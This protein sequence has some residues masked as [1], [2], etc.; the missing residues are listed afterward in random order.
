MSITDIERI[1]DRVTGF[2]VDLGLPPESWA[3]STYA[4]RY[5][6]VVV[7]VSVFEAAGACWVRV[8]APV[9]EEFRPNLE[10]VTRILRLNTELLLG[11]FVIFEDDTLS[12]SVTLAG[13]GLEREPF[14]I[15][16]DHVARIANAYGDEL[17]TIAGGRSILDVLEP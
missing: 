16:L 10:L 8:A 11:S 7:F 2:L 12:F 9:L 14:E 15:A 3:E 17:A 6:K 13:A 1:E 4:F 5:E